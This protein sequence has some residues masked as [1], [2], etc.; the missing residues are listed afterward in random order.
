M[1][2]FTRKA[3]PALAGSGTPPPLKY[4]TEVGKSIS[5]SL[6]LSLSFTAAKPDPPDLL[7]FPRVVKHKLRVELS[8]VEGGFPLKL[9]CEGLF[10]FAV[11]DGSHTTKAGE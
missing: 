7:S 11:L 9:S 5:L 1:T 10:S 3:M 4:Q 8:T 2:H 6:S